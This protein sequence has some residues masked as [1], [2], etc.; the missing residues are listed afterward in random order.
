MV[1]IQSQIATQEVDEFA[2]SGVRRPCQHCRRPVVLLPTFLGRRLIFDADP[3]AR[4][5]EDRHGWICGMFPL[6]G[7]FQ[8]VLAPGQEHPYRFRRYV[9]RALRLHQCCMPAEDAQS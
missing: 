1:S 3:I 9:A 8:W 6:G 4:T 7:H 5:P 2:I